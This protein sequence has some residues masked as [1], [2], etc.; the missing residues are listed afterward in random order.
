MMIFVKN[1]TLLSIYSFDLFGL[2]FGDK[3]LTVAA[4]T[5]EKHVVHYRQ[6]Y[7]QLSI[8]KTTS[9]EMALTL[10]LYVKRWQ[11]WGKAAIGAW[12]TVPSAKPYVAF[13]RDIRC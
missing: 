11:Q 12:V 13:S 4:K 1:D 10:G 3:R 9:N 6:L 5:V 8:K 7:E 2:P